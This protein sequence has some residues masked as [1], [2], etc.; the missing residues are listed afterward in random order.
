MLNVMGLKYLSLANK[1]LLSIS[2]FKVQKYQNASL[3]R[4]LF[5]CKH[6]PSPRVA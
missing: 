1:K 3:W 4:I 5:K 6:I 2:F